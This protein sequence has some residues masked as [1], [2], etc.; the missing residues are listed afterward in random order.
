MFG[1]GSVCA[2]EGPKERKKRGGGGMGTAVVGSHH[3]IYELTVNLIKKN[4]R[5]DQGK[6][7]SQDSIKFENFL[8]EQ[9]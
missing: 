3:G 1:K 2:D 6:F 5:P 8:H 9:S 4:G 7:Q